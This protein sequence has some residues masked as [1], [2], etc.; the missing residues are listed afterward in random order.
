MSQSSWWVIK[1]DL[2]SAPEVDL[3][4]WGKITRICSAPSA[5]AS[6][7]LAFATFFKNLICF[8]NTCVCTPVCVQCLKVWMSPRGKSKQV[9]PVV[10]SLP[11]PYF[12]SFHSLPP[13]P[14]YDL[15]CACYESDPCGCYWEW[16]RICARAYVR[17]STGKCCQRLYVTLPAKPNW[18][19]QV[20]CLLYIRLGTESLCS[21]WNLTRSAR[22]NK[23]LVLLIKYLWNYFQ[24]FVSNL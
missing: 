15:F 6:S 20:C 3:H 4:R 10:Y 8:V 21:S 9:H 7:A 19:N 5:S 14:S 12:P 1:R 2:C 22:I 18:C 13:S 11:L 24:Y 16:A 23:E 17:V